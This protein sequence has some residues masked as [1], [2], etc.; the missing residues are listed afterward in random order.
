MDLEHQ[1]TGVIQTNTTPIIFTVPKGEY[2]FS[3]LTSK[4]ATAFEHQ[5]SITIPTNDDF[6]FG[7]THTGHN[8][9]VYCNC[10]NINVSTSRGLNTAAYVI[11]HCNTYKMDSFSEL[12]FYDRILF[13]GG[14]LNQVSSAR[15]LDTSFE[16]S[17]IVITHKTHP[18]VFDVSSDEIKCSIEI[19]WG[20]H[21][22]SGKSVECSDLVLIMKFDEIQPLKTFFEHY[23]KIRDLLSFMTFRYNVGF[24][25]I[26][27]A[28]TQSTIKDHGI[29][30]NVFVQESAQWAQKDYHI[31]ICFEEIEQHLP[32]LLTTLYH[33]QDKKP[34]LILGFLPET[35]NDLFYITNS[36]IRNLCSALESEISQRKDI[37]KSKNDLITDLKK[38]ALH[39]VKEFRKENPGLT[40]DQC[41]LIQGSIGNWSLPLSDKL[42][43]LLHL[44][45]DEMLLLSRDEQEVS[46]VDIV[47]FVKYRNSITH[48]NHNTITQQIAKTAFY[49][50]GLVYLCI[51][52][53]IG[54]TRDEIKQLCQYKLLR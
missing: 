40:D 9:A 20:I 43:A 47:E 6:I 52:E 35:D 14:T 42:C 25:K 5:D 16:T 46:D 19:N 32:T 17:N 49:L 1:I 24:S 37:K 29:S 4:A 34:A 11:S 28:N 33:V 7:K 30:A 54:M 38:R 13:Y 12:G 8:I 31:N 53:R 10:E 15:K 39:L 26:E 44:F 22:V 27:I 21:E 18:I 23:N 2:R 51:L 50:Q 3:F 45:D 36:K 41:S 48:G